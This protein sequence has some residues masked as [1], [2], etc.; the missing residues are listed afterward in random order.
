MPS[1]VVRTSQP[2]DRLHE[3]LCYYY[4]TYKNIEGGGGQKSLYMT[5]STK[6]L[7]MSKSLMD[8]ILDESSFKP[9]NQKQPSQSS[10]I[11]LNILNSQ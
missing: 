4:N 11:I 3:L 1:K 9:S 6:L 5:Y 8:N 7:I 10:L 2:P